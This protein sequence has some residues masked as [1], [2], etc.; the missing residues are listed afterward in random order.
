MR[1]IIAALSIL[2]LSACAAREHEPSEEVD[3]CASIEAEIVDAVQASKDA[4]AEYNILTRGRVQTAV[5]GAAAAGEKARIAT[6]TYMHMVVNNPDCFPAVTVA[7]AESL[8]P[9]MEQPGVVPTS[10]PVPNP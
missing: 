3:P 1:G 7:R 2:V 10:K 6:L 8:I 4:I 5:P 9:S